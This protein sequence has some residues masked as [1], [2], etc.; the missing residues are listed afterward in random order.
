[1][2]FSFKP[3][4]LSLYAMSYTD[5]YYKGERMD[6][7][8]IGL[9][10]I[11][12]GVVLT[13]VFQ[14]V[15]KYIDYRISSK[16]RWLHDKKQTYANF[17]MTSNTWFRHSLSVSRQG[18][19]QELKDRYKQTI[20]DSRY[21]LNSGLAMINVIGA[22]KV[23]VEVEAF[24]DWMHTTSTIAT[25]QRPNSEEIRRYIEEFIEKRAALTGFFRDDL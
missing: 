11:I 21:E 7:S 17:L 22:P 19:G 24:N 23:V 12:V 16:N 18:A 13:S 25:K 20:I 9:I 1:M 3:Q 2:A 8:A 6:A 10:G 14:L 4:L 5:S 15:N